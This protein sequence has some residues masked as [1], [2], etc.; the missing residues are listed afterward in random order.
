MSEKK[1]NKKSVQTEFAEKIQSIVNQLPNSRVG[2][3]VGVSGSLRNFD[4]VQFVPTPSAAAVE[5]T[6]KKKK[7]PK[8]VITKKKKQP[9]KQAVKK[10][11]NPLI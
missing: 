5:T 9:K 11:T 8:N 2:L 1:S 3:D 10:Y 7:Q 6:P 4:S